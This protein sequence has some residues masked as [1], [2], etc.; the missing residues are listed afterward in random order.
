MS[1]VTS[2]QDYLD[3]FYTLAAAEPEILGAVYEKV[4]DNCREAL[5]LEFTTRNLLF[6]ANPDD[7]TIHVRSE[8]TSSSNTSEWT[9][10]DAKEPW[11]SLI[12]TAFGW[13][14]I[15]INQQGYCDGVLLSFDGVL[16]T[17][18]LCVIGSGITVRRLV[19]E[20]ESTVLE[21]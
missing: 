1:A 13:G 14:W 9:R 17:I 19:E 2:C 6:T 15:T 18:M 11:K 7:D 3:S 5:T 12:G 16:P 21:K 10:R 4:T 8:D 20:E